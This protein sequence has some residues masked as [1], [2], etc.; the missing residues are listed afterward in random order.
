[1]GIK[2]RVKRRKTGGKEEELVDRMRQADREDGVE[3]CGIVNY[4]GVPCRRKAGWGT[5]HFGE[6]PCK[7]HEHPS[8]QLALKRNKQPSSYEGHT[9]M[10]DL[11]IEAY[12]NPQM[13]QVDEEIA[14]MRVQM[15]RIDDALVEIQARH[16]NELIPEVLDD[17][18]ASKHD[19]KAVMSLMA[20]QAKVAETIGKLIDRKHK[21]EEGKIVTYTQVKEV[22]GKVG[23]II[24]KT[25]NGCEKLDVLAEQFM[26]IDLGRLKP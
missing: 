20:Q 9:C 25:C 7:A 3:R 24:K 4:E 14:K 5:N 21:M 10:L 19:H 2:V 15:A 26:S 11:F 6:G 13:K 17:D 1:M 23:Y 22:L 16:G 18:E 8:R 12:E